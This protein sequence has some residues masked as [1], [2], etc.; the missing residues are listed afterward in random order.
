[1]EAKQRPSPLIAHS[2]TDA[3]GSASALKHAP[4]PR[5]RVRCVPSMF[6]R[7]GVKVP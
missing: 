7:L 2:L 3:R 5:E 4:L 6:N 1:L